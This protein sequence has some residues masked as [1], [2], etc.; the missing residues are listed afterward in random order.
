MTNRSGIKKVVAGVLVAGA[1]TLSSLASGVA[2]ADINIGVGELQECTI[3][4][5][6]DGDGDVDG[7]DFLVWQRSTGPSAGNEVA[8]EGITLAYE[9]FEIQ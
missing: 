3:S 6:M 1:I 8:V 9:G 4:K 2:S 5:S 7:R